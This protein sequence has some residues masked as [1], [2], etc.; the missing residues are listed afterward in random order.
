MKEA[1]ETE[2]M[3]D[4]LVE[5]LKGGFAP[6]VTL[7]REFDYSKAAEV[8]D[9]LPY[10]AWSL[11]EHMC[12]RQS[13]MLRFMKNPAAVD[14]LWPD[15][16]WPEN[17]GPGNELIWEQ[18]ISSFEQDLAEIISIVEDPEVPLFESQ[19]NGKTFFWAA[20]ATLQHNAYHIGQIKAIGRQL[21]V[22]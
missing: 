18:G 22:W 21:G 15:A 19:R 12:S 16:Y 6:V 2:T 13:L 7:L 1:A 9:G 3:R 5:L 17:P 14:N 11:L 10:S 8:L 4:E 20:V